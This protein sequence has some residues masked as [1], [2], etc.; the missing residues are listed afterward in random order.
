[1]FPEGSDLDVAIVSSELYRQRHTLVATLLVGGG[2]AWRVWMGAR[3]ALT[4][5]DG[6]IDGVQGWVEGQGDRDESG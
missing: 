3:R 4:F 5:A 1:M 6:N 2:L